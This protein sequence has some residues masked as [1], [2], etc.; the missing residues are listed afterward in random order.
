MIKFQSVI[1]I[2]A[3][4]ILLQG[5][6]GSDGNP[7]QANGPSNGRG[8][9][10]SDD[11]TLALQEM[12][13]GELNEAETAALLFMREEEKL[14][15]DVYD[16]LYS[17]WGQPVFDNISASET[18]HTESV[19]Q[20]LER[21]QIDDPARGRAAGDFANPDLQALYDTLIDRGSASLIDALLVGA[22]IEEID[23]IDIQ[24]RIAQVEDNDDIVLVYDNLMKGSRNHLRSFVKNLSNQAI[25]YAPTHLDQDS[26]DAII[27]AA[28]ETGQR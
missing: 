8:P 9:D 2:I 6:G 19:L 13:V 7:T 21:Y 22:E 14:A 18:A 16:L 27:E 12:P 15:R 28:I 4:L 3:M 25:S 20:L 17:V 1:A 23:I 24:T 5:C 11:I 26:Y 10:S